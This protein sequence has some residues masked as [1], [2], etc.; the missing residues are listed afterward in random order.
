MQAEM[1]IQEAEVPVPAEEVR[2]AEAPAEEATAVPGAQEAE[3]QVVPEV[4]IREA[5]DREVPVA[6]VSEQAAQEA[7]AQERVIWETQGA[8]IREAVDRAVPVAAVSE[9]AA[10]EA[11]GVEA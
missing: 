4:R 1:K 6:T 2:I 8:G 7:E 9:R 3:I 10:Q 11:L 5:L